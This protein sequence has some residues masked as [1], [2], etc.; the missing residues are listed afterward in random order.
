MGRCGA[1]LARVVAGTMALGLPG[2][3]AQ[4]GT[5]TPPWSEGFD[6]YDVGALNGR[7]PWVDWYNYFM[8]QASVRRG[9]GQGVR[10]DTSLIDTYGVPYRNRWGHRSQEAL[11]DDVGSDRGTGLD[12][13][14]ILSCYVKSVTQ[15]AHQRPAA[16]GIDLRDASNA[17]IGGIALGTEQVIDLMGGG[18]T[19]INTLYD[20]TPFDPSEWNKIAVIADL[21]GRAIAFAVNDEIA[22]AGGHWLTDVGGF[23]LQAIGGSTGTMP[24]SAQQALLYWDELDLRTRARC[25]GDLNLD[26]LIDDR[27]FAI[28][29]EQYALVDCADVLMPFACSADLNAD[30]LA[31]DDDFVIFAAG[32]RAFACP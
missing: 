20:V 25:V 13:V 31:S 22:A 3:A 15:G 21:E 11:A 6:A 29:L 32:Y 23:S 4:A 5:V 17:T 9:A 2:A 30:G 1:S 8:V 24:F 19:S 14:V 10:F 26:E 12:R 7:G 27:D 16:A 18:F 28:F